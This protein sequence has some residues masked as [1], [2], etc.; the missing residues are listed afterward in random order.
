M[1]L[2]LQHEQA[3]GYVGSGYDEHPYKRQRMMS[4]TMTRSGYDHDQRP[5]QRPYMPGRGP[6]GQYPMRDPLATA[7]GTYYA[8]SALQPDTTPAADYSFMHQRNNSASTTSPFISPRTEYPNYGVST[9]N[10]FYQQPQRAQTYQYPQTQY[11][12]RPIM[13]ETVQALPPYRPPLVAAPPQLDQP[14][15]YSRPLESE[16]Q[17]LS[18]RNYHMPS[19]PEY[20]N[21]QAETSALYDSSGQALTRTL[22]APSQPLTGVLPPLPSTLPSSQPRRGPVQSYSSSIVPSTEGNA[23]FVPTNQTLQ[24]YMPQPYRGHDSG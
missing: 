1:G 12:G 3:G 7:R 10:S 17:G 18:D 6:Y 5:S 23:Q 4:E 21:T 20:Q 14:R 11:A 24:N 2:Q 13:P 15:P 8:Q 16:D 9:P 22:P 19:R